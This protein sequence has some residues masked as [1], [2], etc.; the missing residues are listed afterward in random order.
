MVRNSLRFVSWKDDKAAT[1]DLKA[2][3]QAPTEEAGQQELEAFASVWDSRFGWQYRQCNC[4]L[5]RPDSAFA[6]S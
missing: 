6:L 2:I 3:Y 5:I 1:C 4:R